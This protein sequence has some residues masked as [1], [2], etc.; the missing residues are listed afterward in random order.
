MNYYFELPD[1]LSDLIDEA[2]LD[3]DGL[4][5]TAY[6]AFGNQWHFPDWRGRRGGACRV[7]V[8]GG[9]IAART[10]IK[11]GAYADPQTFE[12]YPGFLRGKLFALDFARK[13]ELLEAS[14]AMTY[15]GDGFEEW[16]RDFFYQ[17]C[18]AAEKDYSEEQIALF[19]R[20]NKNPPPLAEYVNWAE[21]DKFKESLRLIAAQ[22]REVGL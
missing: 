2:L 3:I 1:K 7:C 22:L 4:D 13:G 20:W 17:D 5:R 16:Q 9:V 6:A 15:D 12:D 11:T 10:D 18:A 8:A 14:V 21:Y 19:D